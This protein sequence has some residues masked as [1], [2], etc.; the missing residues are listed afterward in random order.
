MLFSPGRIIG[1]MGLIKPYGRYRNLIL[2]AETDLK[3][4][5]DNYVCDDG[6]T[7]EGMG[8]WGHSFSS[9][10]PVVY[11]LSR[12]HSKNISEYVSASLL[13][14]ADYALN[15]L[16]IAGDGTNFL[17]INNIHE[18][19]QLKLGLIG[20][21]YRLTGKNEFKELFFKTRKSLKDTPDFFDILMSIEEESPGNIL[22]EER[23]LVLGKIGHISYV[24]KDKTLTNT[25]FHLTSGPF[26]PG[27][28]HQDKGSFII[29]TTD[30]VLAKDRGVCNYSYAEHTLMQF[31]DK[32]NLLYPERE[33]G[34]VTAQPITSRGS[35]IIEARKDGEEVFMTCDNK[36]AWEEGLFDKNIRS[37]YSPD[38]RIYI[39]ND[40]V[41]MRDECRMSFIVNSEHDIS[42]EE[43]G[44]IVKGKTS[45]LYVFPIN[46]EPERVVTGVDGLD[47]H[48]REVKRGRIITEKAKK[49]N[50]KTGMIIIGK[51]G[52]TGIK[53]SVKKISEDNYALEYA[54]KSY[55]I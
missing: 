16:S 45:F 22:E 2:E 37:V 46:Y 8:Y 7:L 52:F 17:P 35:V 28:N 14:T 47:S 34:K 20:A 51:E 10:L 18:N 44:F 43:K 32:H 4:M 11:V 21:F 50:L 19:F 36:D 27:H 13:K 30:E 24:A 49:H 33:D 38:N 12:Y 9:C 23:F 26:G 25:H 55:G 40:I 39:V 41:E 54:N 6:G 1:M 3:E 15:M 42:T 5:I 29:E 48:L 53:Y 31:P